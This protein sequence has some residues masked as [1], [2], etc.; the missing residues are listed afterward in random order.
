MGN[1]HLPFPGFSVKEASVMFQFHGTLGPGRASGT[2]PQSVPQLAA[3]PV[4]GVL[5]Y[6]EGSLHN[7]QHP[8]VEGQSS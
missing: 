5:L 1:L 4:Q 7:F 2:M 6:F 3:G 8:R